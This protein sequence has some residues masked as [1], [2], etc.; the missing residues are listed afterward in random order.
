METYHFH[1]SD[2]VTTEEIGLQ[3]ALNLEPGNIVLLH[4]N[5][6]AGKTVMTR[7]IARGLGVREAISSPTFA[8]VQEYEG[9]S[10][11]LYHIDLY[12]LADIHAADSFGIED[13]MH[14]PDAIT[15]IEWP[16]RIQEI[17]D[18][19]MIQVNIKYQSEGRD[20]QINSS[21]PLSFDLFKDQ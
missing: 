20:I 1:S 21:K 11:R 4:A 9:L 13:Y 2:E 14:D 7:G 15:V 17:I 16:S 10:C 8:I 12:R 6:G 5:L 3:L 18:N 19:S